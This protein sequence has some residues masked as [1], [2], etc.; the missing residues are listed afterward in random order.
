MRKKWSVMLF[1]LILSLF[2]TACGGGNQETSTE[3]DGNSN[4]GT[5]T[6]DTIVLDFWQIDSGEKEAVYQDAIERFEKKNP[7]VEVNMLRIP[8]DDYKQR[9]VVAM[10]GGNPPDVFTSWGGG[11]LKEFA[12]AGQV[13]DLTNE[14]I[15]FDH[16]LEM[17]LNNTTFDE[18]VYGLPL[19]LSQTLFFYNKEIFERHS[20]EEPETY[21]ELL[22]IIDELNE[23][24]VIPITL[25]NQTKWPGAY[26]L[27]YFADRL[28]SEELFQ[29]AFNRDGKGFDDANYVRA[30]EYIQE[31]VDRNAFNPGFNGVPYDAGQGRQLLYSGQSAMMLMTNTL[32]VNVRSEAPEFEEKLGMFPFPTLPDGEGDPTNVGGATSPVWSAYS[33]TEHP[34]LAIELM[35]E[36]TTL[37]TA[38]DYVNRTGSLS[39]LI[40]VPTDDVFVQQFAEMAV[41]A[42]DIHMPYDQTLPPVLAELHKDT[43]QEL[44]GKTMTPQE[45][46]DLMEQKAKETLD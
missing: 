40:D 44:F 39:A 24:D 14:D 26:Y 35:K 15:D 11:W 36:L 13:L 8:N 21:D 42:N 6:G 9:M 34:E 18:K 3:A 5:S 32:V 43:T 31:L 23:N 29:S 1:A 45:A 38:E 19:G 30:G 46:A 37:E 7:G 16:F 22:A 17:A 25:T 41:E 33:G 12:D 10:S 2:V 4:E 28:G 20:L 27:M